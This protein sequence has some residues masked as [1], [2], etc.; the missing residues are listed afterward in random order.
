MQ[1]SHRKR[2]DLRVFQP[3][4][5]DLNG[6]GPLQDFVAA[7]EDAGHTAD[8]PEPPHEHETVSEAA[9]GAPGAHSRG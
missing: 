9:H 6:D 8:G 5:K 7:E 4:F 3:G 1:S 2:G